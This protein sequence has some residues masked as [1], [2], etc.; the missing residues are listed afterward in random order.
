MVTLPFCFCFLWA[1]A[2]MINMWNVKISR[3]RF[4]RTYYFSSRKG[5]SASSK[6]HYHSE[7]SQNKGSWIYLDPKIKK[8]QIVFMNFRGNS[9]YRYLDGIW[10]ITPCDEHNFQN[11]YENFL[12]YCIYQW[13]WRYLKACFQSIVN[14]VATSSRTGEIWDY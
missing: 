7:Q 3:N 10:V 9:D 8:D 2:S 6:I 4:W 13:Y 14:I 11:A 1:F 12:K 5:I